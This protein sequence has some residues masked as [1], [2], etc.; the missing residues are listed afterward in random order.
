MIIN[1]PGKGWIQVK[2]LKKLQNIWNKH[3][4]PDKDFLEPLKVGN[5]FNPRF[6]LGWQFGKDNQP[7]EWTNLFAVLKTWKKHPNCMFHKLM[8]KE[9][10]FIKDNLIGKFNNTIAEALELKNDKTKL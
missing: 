1:K 4:D 8:K 10:L 9:K 7:N 3:Y 6:Q 2:S 5:V